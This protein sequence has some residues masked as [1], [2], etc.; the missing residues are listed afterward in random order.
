VTGGPGAAG[1]E[2]SEQQRA[3][4]ADERFHG[5]AKVQGKTSVLRISSEGAVARTDLRLTG[6]S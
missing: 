5:A 3:G 2:Q 4:G 1:K 6:H